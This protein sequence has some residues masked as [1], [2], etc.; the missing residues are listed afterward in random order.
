MRTLA[1]IL[2]LLLLAAGSVFAARNYFPAES[3]M[4]E[5]KSSA[6]PPEFGIGALGRIEPMSEVLHI[7]APSMMEQPLI[8]ELLVKVGDEVIAGQLLARL[9]SHRRELADVGSA[10]AALNLAETNLERVLAG[11]KAGEIVAQE[12]LV[13]RAKS[14]LELAQKKLNRAEKLASNQA[15]S[16]EDL[17]VARTEFEIEQ[18]ELHQHEATL[19]AIREI[20]PVDINYAK[21]QIDQAKADLERAEADLDVTTIKSPIDGVVL[22]I[23]TRVGERVGNDG[24]L[25]LGDTSEMDVVAEVH[26]TDIIRVRLGQST[27]VRLRNWNETLH[28]HVIEIGRLVG[29]MDVLS[30][31]PVDDTDARVVEVRIRLDQ[32]SGNSVAGMSYA[33]VEATIHPAIQKPDS[34]I[35]LQSGISGISEARQ[36]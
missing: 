34:V 6:P 30:N 26:E 10:H 8:S 33:R 13:E 35:E 23:N 29:R 3:R 7:N 18:R 36:E 12:S 20:R 9:D 22:E 27:D 11:A 5:S 4:G 24:L 14:R 31:D 15:L 1:A 28:G 21:A 2:F 16:A 32:P 19:E 17:D 25:E